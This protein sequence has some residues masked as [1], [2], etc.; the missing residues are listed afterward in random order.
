MQIQETQPI[1]RQHFWD[2]IKGILILSVL[3]IHSIGGWNFIEWDYYVSKETV[4]FNSW[5]LVSIVIGCAVGIFIFISGSFCHY[6]K[7]QAKSRHYLGKRIKNFALLF[8]VWSCMYSVIDLFVYE[9]NITWQSVL[10]GTNGIQL[11]FLLVMLQL[12]IIA[13]FLLKHLDDKKIWLGCFLISFFYTCF[14]LGYWIFNSRIIPNELLLFAN[15]IIFYFIG[16]LYGNGRFNFAKISLKKALFFVAI[17]LVIK[18]VESYLLLTYTNDA[19]VAT[20]FVS[21]ANL[22]YTLSIIVL[23]CVVKTK[24][25]KKCRFK[26]LEYI[27]QNTMDI[28]LVHWFFEAPLYSVLEPLVQNG[29]M[30]I[31]QGI[32][33][34]I[35][36]VLSLLYSNIKQF[37]VYKWRNGPSNRV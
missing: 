30:V 27:G 5:L 21:P 12:M 13:P 2:A 35:T 34:G 29:M 24:V 32:Q 15:W 36:L 9:K 17:T 26:F 19:T 11:Y 1:N 8:V 33:I 6:E 20:S 25:D 16:L 28:F 37:I 18:I 23:L 10:L 3:Y 4:S 14:S 7:T 31:A 22:F